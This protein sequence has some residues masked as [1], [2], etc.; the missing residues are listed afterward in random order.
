MIAGFMEQ[1]TLESERIA[2]RH[3]QDADA[4]ILYE[5]AREPEVG[6]RAG[7]PPHQAREE[8][9][10]VIRTVLGNPTSWWIAPY[11]TG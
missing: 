3:W 2:L 8:W 4:D 7:W 9:L 5:Y 6:E 11:Y 10:E 1:E